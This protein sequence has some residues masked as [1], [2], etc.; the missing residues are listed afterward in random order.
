MGGELGTKVPAGGVKS[1]SWLEGRRECCLMNE[2]SSIA[3]RAK[4]QS[5]AIVVLGWYSFGSAR[6]KAE[7][8]W[9]SE[10]REA[11]FLLLYIT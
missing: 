4:S 2:E 9:C 7:R 11:V 8:G 1:S 6:G 10:D 3:R 5:E